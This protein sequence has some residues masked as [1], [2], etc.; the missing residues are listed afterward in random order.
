M[1]LSKVVGDLHSHLPSEEI[2]DGL[3]RSCQ[4]SFGNWFC[5]FIDRHGGD[6]DG[7]DGGGV[8]VVMMVMVMMMVVGDK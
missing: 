8:G 7:G 3:P 4:R 5:G 6:G 1:F 2:A